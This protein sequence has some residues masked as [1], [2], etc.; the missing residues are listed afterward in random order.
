[1][2]KGHVFIAQSLDGFIARVDHALD[3]LNKQQ[4]SGEEHGY[5]AFIKGMDGL[6]MGANTFRQVKSFEVWPYEI[7]VVVM[8][9]SL[10]ADAIP[11]RLA[12]K[13]RL[14]RTRPFRLMQVLEEEGWSNVY[15]DGGAL[16][17]RFLRAGLTHEITLTT[18]PVLLGHGRRLF[19][20]LERDVDLSLERAQ[21]FASGLI[22]CRYRILPTLDVS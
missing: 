21:S 19:G 13:V 20:A 12:D 6:V 7:P 8:S 4:V 3:W 18:V 10:E 1:M 16:I 15:V 5:D 2:P 9:Q 11:E 17:Q 14:T 22:T